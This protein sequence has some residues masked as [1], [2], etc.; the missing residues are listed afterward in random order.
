MKVPPML[1]LVKQDVTGLRDEYLTECIIAAPGLLEARDA[2]MMLA[3]PIDGLGLTIVKDR[4]R[5]TLLGPA[6]EKLE[7][8]HAR[9]YRDDYVIL[10][11]GTDQADYVDPVET[12]DGSDEIRYDSEEEACAVA[13][14]GGVDVL[15]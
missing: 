8:R 10:A 6:T 5:L 7:P 4:L 15:G 11:I 9:F 12:Q 3:D 1:Y 2:A 13:T 14:A